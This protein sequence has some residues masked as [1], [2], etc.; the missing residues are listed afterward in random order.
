[1]R[2]SRLAVV[3][4]PVTAAALLVAASSARKDPHGVYAV[5]DSV[6]F[7]PVSAR[8]PQRIQVWGS[9]A[10]ANVVGMKDGKIV[11]I[12]FGH[13]HPPQRG[14][15]YYS[16]NPN[17]EAETR[18]YWAELKAIAGT[19]HAAAWGAHLPPVGPRRPLTMQDTAAARHIMA[20]NGRVRAPMEPRVNADVFPQPMSAGRIEIRAN[21][22]RA[23]QLGLPVRG[24]ASVFAPTL[25]PPPP[26]D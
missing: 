12:Q 1:M 26:R 5:V 20:Y 25:T 3:L 7:E 13:F 19:G 2:I 11:H 10:L 24:T 6:V 17:D 22:T 9:F 14:Y 4:V 18:H 8:V 21:A 23:A 16:V 15:M